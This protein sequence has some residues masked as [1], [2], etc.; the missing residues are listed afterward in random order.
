MAAV[1]VAVWAAV[2][3]T[4]IHTVPRRLLSDD[5]EP[6][7]HAHRALGSLLA[8]VAH[9]LPLAAGLAVSMVLL[10]GFGRPHGLAAVVTWTALAAVSAVVMIL[11]DRLSRRLLPLAAL[12]KLSLVFPDRSPRRLAVARKAGQLKDLHTQLDHGHRPGDGTET[13]A[14]AAERIVAL[15]AALHAHDRRTRGH[16]ERVRVLTDVLADELRL[17]RVDRDRLRWAALLHDVGKLEVPRRVLNKPGKLTHREWDT[18]HQHP[19]AGHRI[20]AALRPWLGSWAP[21]IVEH[22]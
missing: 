11:V 7:W 8:A 18:I 12:Y 9:L 14:E 5:G 19:E 16:S 21:A 3:G 10:R 1:A 22:H 17:R 2:V 13:P 4:A 6:R 15:V 20:T